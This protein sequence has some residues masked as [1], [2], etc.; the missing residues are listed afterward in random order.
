M[1]A[2]T[3]LEKTRILVAHGADVN[4]RSDEGRT[5]L[6]IACRRSG[7]KDVVKLLLERGANPSV[8]VGGLVGEVTPLSEAM[9]AGD[10]SIFRLLVEHGADRKAAGPVALAFAYRARCEKC[11][12]ELSAGAGPDVF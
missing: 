3:D 11:V 1:W 9:Y 12:E 8:K 5:P 6:L 4:A 2:V 10:E 7:A